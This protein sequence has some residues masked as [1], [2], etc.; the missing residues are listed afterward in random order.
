MSVYTIASIL[1]T[2]AVLFGYINHHFIRLQSTIAIMSGSL[3]L[4]LIL[5]ILQ[6]LGVTDITMHTRHMLIRMDFHSLLLNG[7]LSFLLFAGALT[8][9][10]QHLKTKKWEIGILASLSTI[11]ST[12]IVGI[13]VYYVLPFLHLTL[14]FSYCLLFGAL[15]SPTDPIAVLATF[16]EINAPKDLEAC[17]SGES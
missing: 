6:N 1:I 17:V 4:S 14:P 5:L 13:I 16:K 15:I 9:D 10:F 7:M 12:F 8:I 3:F 2:L 11:F